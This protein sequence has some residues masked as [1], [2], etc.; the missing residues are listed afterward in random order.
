VHD[1]RND[2]ENEQ[3]MD[4]KTAD[5]EEREATE[6]KQYKDQSDDEKHVDLPSCVQECCAL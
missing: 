6:P 1:N 5:M 2:R 4:E 3:D